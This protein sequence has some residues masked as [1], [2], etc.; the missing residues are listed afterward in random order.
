MR[1]VPRVARPR[2]ALAQEPDVSERTLRRRTAAHR[3]RTRAGKQSEDPALR[4]ADRQSRSVEHDGDHGTAAAHQPQ[5]HDGRWSRRTTKPSSTACAAASSGSK[6][7]RIVTDE[8]RGYYFLDWG[9]VKFFLGEVLR[10]FTRNAGMQLTAIGTVAMTI[11][12]LG[13]FLFVRETLAGLGTE[14]LSQI[15]ISVY[16]TDKCD[17]GARGCRRAALQHDPRVASF[18]SSRRSRASPNSVRRRTETYR[19]GS[20]LT[21]NPL[22]DKLRV[23]AIDPSHVP[24]V[25][26]S[27]RKLTASQMSSS[28]RP[29]S[30]GCS[31]ATCCGASASASSPYSCSSRASSFRTRFA[32]RSSRAGAKS[33]S[34]SSSARPTCTFV[35][36]LSA[37]D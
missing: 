35:R 20:L 4:R 11:V 22:P 5:G 17:D 36:R 8:E 6:T 18:N 3:D 16:F 27:A 23:Q 9:K 34:C 1:Q 33:R 12:L 30:R 28:R 24:A 37:K 14:L 29:S 2:R 31:S 19:H 10:N 21:E 7:A 15:E 13:S 32:S 26:A 25:A